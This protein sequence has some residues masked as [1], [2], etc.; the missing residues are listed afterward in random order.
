MIQDTENSEF[1]SLSMM[2]KANPVEE[3]GRRVIYCEASDESIDAQDEQVMQKALADSMEY[4]LARGNLDIDHITMTGPKLGIPD[5]LT[6]EIGRPEDIRFRDGKTF[7]KG[8]IYS[9]SGRA[10][11]KANDFWSSLTEINPPKRWFPSVGGSVQSS[12]IVIDPTTQAR[13]RRITKVRW[14]NI[15]FS[16]QPVNQQVA[17]VQ[18]VPMEVF[19]KSWA[20]DGF[21]KTLEAG[22]GTDSAGLIGAGAL[23]IQSLHG[24]TDYRDKMAKL[25]LDGVISAKDIVQESITRF[26]LSPGQAGTWA[27]QFLTDLQKR[28]SR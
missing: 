13:Q 23:R 9:G 21:F 24:Y 4:M 26:S 18:T 17:S 28:R 6:Y 20:A 14:S 27:E 22:Y 1:L 19:A 25:L 2:L 5:Y 16:Q 7:V 8:V 12:E 11:E 15:A 3:G 10:A